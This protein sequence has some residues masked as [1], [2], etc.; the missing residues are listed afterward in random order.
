MIK[1]ARQLG[2]A[3]DAPGAGG[4][5]LLVAL[6]A[7]RAFASA[8]PERVYVLGYEAHWA[9]LFSQLFALPCP[10][11]GLTR[12]SLLALDGRLAEAFAL[13]PAAPLVVLGTALLAAALVALALMRRA[14]A[15]SAA[16]RLRQHLRAGV[17]L[18]GALL[19]AVLLV[20]WLAQ[21]LRA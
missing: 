3:G 21:L 20:N 19:G 5:L 10:G 2:W 11:C 6:F 18:Y 1:A 17:R 9:C 16:A 15:P 12:G 7:A 4:A 8:T 13:N 14:R